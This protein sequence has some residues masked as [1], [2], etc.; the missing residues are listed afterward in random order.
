MRFLISVI[1]FKRAELTARCLDA[2]FKSRGDFDLVLTNNGDDEH[3]GRLFSAAQHT[4]RNVTVVTNPTNLGF[5][6]PNNEAFKLAVAGSYDAFVM[7]NNDAVC[8]PD[9][10]ERIAEVFERQPAAAVVGPRHTCCALNDAFHGEPGER[11]E[12]AELSASAVSVAKVAKHFPWLFPPYLSFAYGEDADLS[13]R[14][15]RLGYTIHA[16]NFVIDHQRG[17]TSA[18]VPEIAEYQRRNHDECLR[19][20]GHYLKVRRFE[21]RIIVRRWAAAGDVLMTTPIIRALWEQNPLSP[22]LVETFFPELFDGN[23][24][25]A[26]AGH[27]IARLPTDRVINLDMVSENSPMRH[28]VRSYARAADVEV[29]DKAK[30]EIF[31]KKDPWLAEDW[32]TDQWCALHTGPSTWASKEWPADRFDAVAREL[33]AAG[34]KIVLVGSGRVPGKIAHDLDLR[35]RTSKLN[36]LAALLHHCQLFVGIDSAPMHVAC[37]VG[38]PVVGIFGITQSRFI[39]TGSSIGVDADERIAPRAGERHRVAG[40]THIDEDGSTIRTISVASVMTAIQVL[41]T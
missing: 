26:G 14:M 10:L 1:A 37:A 2:L 7:L 16:A 21:Y 25:V 20:W 9:W 34:W 32:G 38:I 39:L 40:R 5:Q 19:R 12:Y 4:G 8:P 18:L 11:Y 17:S 22:I 33:Q 3:V 23:P 41:L 24:C 36:D 15:R 28:F 27:E 6:I 29:G 30:L 13:L 31:W 35:D